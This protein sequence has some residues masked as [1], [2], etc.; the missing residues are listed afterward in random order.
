MTPFSGDIQY[1]MQNQIAG[2]CLR[3]PPKCALASD[4][5]KLQEQAIATERHTTIR[6]MIGDAMYF[7]S[8]RATSRSSFAVPAE[9]G[10]IYLLGREKVCPLVCSSL[11][12]PSLRILAP[13]INYVTHDEGVGVNS[14]KFRA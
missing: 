13:L 8:R 12:L 1:L 9:L 3:T 2:T 10:P 7:A 4:C 6:A 14:R 11:G 5:V